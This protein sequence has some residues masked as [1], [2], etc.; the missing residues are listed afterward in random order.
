MREHT[1]SRATFRVAILLWP[2][3]MTINSAHGESL[4]GKDLI[5]AL[6]EGGYVILMRHASSP[7]DPPNGAHAEVDNVQHERQLDEGGRTSARDM[8]EALRRFRIPI[9]K[10]LSSPT[11]RALETIKLAQFGPATIFVELGDGGQ[12]MLA[13]KSGARAAW[14]KAKSAEPPMTGRNTII[15]T[16]FPN[17]TE[18]FPRDA[19][20][21]ADGE[22]LIIHPDGGGS[23]RVVALVKIDEW[24][25]L[26]TS[27]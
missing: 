16:H 5:A 3:L 10:V 14:L 4:T 20:G 6:R 24:S 21:L 18:A 8:G 22:A 17:I 9:G 19:V 27:Q 23:A 11:Y 13:D 2:L 15:V 26:D 7:H 1:S 12:S 25:H